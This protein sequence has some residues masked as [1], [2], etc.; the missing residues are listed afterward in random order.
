[1]P[2]YLCVIIVKMEV[3]VVTT[4][5]KLRPMDIAATPHQPDQPNEI[6][7]HGEADLMDSFSAMKVT[8]GIMYKRTADTMTI[9]GTPVNISRFKRQDINPTP[10]KLEGSS[11]YS[12]SVHQFKIPPSLPEE[13]SLEEEVKLLVICSA[14]QEHNT[15]D[16]QENALRTALLCGDEGCLRRP[17][18][19]NRI[20]WIDSDNLTGAPL[21]DL[22]R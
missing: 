14:S 5:V 22:L 19:R 4:P 10:I 2:D 18:L 7:G 20:K 9:E 13:K 11:F 3:N 17:E 12:E 1:M 15:G 21:V 16:H 6:E 8:Q